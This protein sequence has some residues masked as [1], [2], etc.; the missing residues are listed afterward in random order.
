MTQTLDRNQVKDRL[1]FRKI[2]PSQ[3]SIPKG[4]EPDWNEVEKYVQELGKRGVIPDIII[5]SINELVEG[6][7]QLEAVKK[8]KQ[9][10]ILARVTKD[11]VSNNLVEVD[12]SKL[13]PHPLQKEI[14]GDED[15][16]ES[17]V[18][19]AIKET[20]R[21]DPITITPDHDN[22]GFY[23]IVVG[24]TRWLSCIELGIRRISAYVEFFICDLDE[25]EVFLSSNIQREKT[26]EQKAKM[27]FRWWQI[28]ERRN[29]QRKS[30]NNQQHTR[31]GKNFTTR[32]EVGDLVG[33]SG[34]TVQHAIKVVER[35]RELPEAR[36]DEVRKV[37]AKSVDA[38]YKELY[39]PKVE[40]AS[41]WV[42][43]INDFV[44]V[45]GG[46]Y[47]GKRGEIRGTSG[48]SC[49]V[50][51]EGE[52]VF[53]H[54][55]HLR[56]LG[57][58]PSSQP[59]QPT[60]TKQELKAKAVELGVKSGLQALPDI[61][62]NEGFN[63]QSCQPLPASYTGLSSPVDMALALVQM[64]PEQ[65]SQILEIALPDMVPAQIDAIDNAISKQ[66]SK[67]A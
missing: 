14:Y 3:I 53:A 18:F 57:E 66:W 11:N 17:K 22:P 60:S 50:L 33:W 10:W 59:K 24:H 64:A 55:Y 4:I 41:K 20:R 25:E 62:R 44:E 54:G 15:I 38:A 58:E 31:D 43:K 45:T 39:P 63:P 35:L 61:K 42:P 67:A 65:I 48:S 36:V 23:R 8:L 9:K 29:A 51:I 6:I 13:T 34:Y 16:H 21:V 37:L 26:N 47:E 1:D 30:L 32:E 12:V 40:A 52:T 56:P 7:N 46:E 5:T 27:A 2:K 28:V 49:M 19:K